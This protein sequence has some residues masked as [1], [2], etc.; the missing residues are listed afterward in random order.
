MAIFIQWFE[1]PAIV[2]SDASRTTFENA[3]GDTFSLTRE[4]VEVCVS[5]VTTTSTY[6]DLVA[7]YIEFPVVPRVV[8]WPAQLGS[9]HGNR[10]DWRLELCLTFNG[11]I[12]QIPVKFGSPKGVWNLQS[13]QFFFALVDE[14]RRF[15]VVENPDLL[16]VY[17]QFCEHPR[18][19]RQ[20]R[21]R[22]LVRRLLSTPT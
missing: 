12:D 10:T 17:A 13:R 19:E 3:S 9:G 22:P 16:S 14:L 4:G 18:W 5:G 21:S 7:L 1:E 11:L 20:F 15:D 2:T 6:A 8:A